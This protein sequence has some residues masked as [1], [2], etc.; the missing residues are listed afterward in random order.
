MAGRQVDL[1]APA[2]AGAQAYLTEPVQGSGP[3]LVLCS[4]NPAA[5]RGLADLPVAGRASAAKVLDPG[6]PSNELMAN[7][8]QSA[9]KES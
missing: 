4:E 9:G 8:P 3:G 2:G 5:L 7:W 6:L 1:A